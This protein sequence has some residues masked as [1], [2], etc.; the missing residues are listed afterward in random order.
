MTPE[1]IAR[2]A[3]ENRLVAALADQVRARQALEEWKR[4]NP[5][6]ALPEPAH[7]DKC[8]E[9]CPNCQPEPSPNVLP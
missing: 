7:C 9:G 5:S 4:R 3:E 1:M 8:F 6:D 2:M